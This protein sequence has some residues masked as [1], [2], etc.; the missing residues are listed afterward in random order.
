M[1]EPTYTLEQ[2]KLLL[3]RQQCEEEMTGQAK[4]RG[5]AHPLGHPLV[6]VMHG[7]TGLLVHYRCERCGARFV[8]AE[9][10]CQ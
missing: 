4:R 3:R 10:D 5:T 1:T 9:N 2:A 6:K 7:H 8:E